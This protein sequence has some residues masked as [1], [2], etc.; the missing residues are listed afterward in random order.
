[1][2]EYNLQTVSSKFNCRSKQLHAAR[3]N[4]DLLC[5]H[6]ISCIA[7]YHQYDTV[8]HA[9]LANATSDLTGNLEIL[10]FL[11]NYVIKS[12]R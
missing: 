10:L 9:Q 2:F 12:P 6:I 3:Q 4:F 8:K 7:A 1:M 5:R 11:V